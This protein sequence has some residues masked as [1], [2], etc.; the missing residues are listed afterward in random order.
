MT[1][2]TLCP[3]RKGNGFKV[4]VDGVW[5]YTSTKE[6]AAFRNGSAAAVKFRSIDEWKNAEEA[7]G[8]QEPQLQ[9][10]PT[11]TVE[12]VSENVTIVTYD[13]HSPSGA[14]L[15]PQTQHDF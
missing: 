14:E 7:E 13:D 5:Y 10:S 1:Q 6:M 4:V 9:T 3:T 11:T 12:Q 2:A 8:G 15:A